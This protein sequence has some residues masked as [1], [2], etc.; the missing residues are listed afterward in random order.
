MAAADIIEA[1]IDAYERLQPMDTARAAPVHDALAV[2]YLVD[3]AVVSGRRAHVDVETTGE[4]TLGRT[5]IDTQQRFGQ[6][7]NAFVALDADAPRF[8]ALLL[9]TL[10][11]GP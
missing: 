2:A 6:E 3:P 7:P 9:E 1:R 8:V 4:L 10:G 5:V 11:L